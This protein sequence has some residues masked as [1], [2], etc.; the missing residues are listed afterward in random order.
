MISCW[1]N[2]R[3]GSLLGTL[4]QL[5]RR[6]K[7]NRIPAKPVGTPSINFT[8]RLYDSCVFKEQMSTPAI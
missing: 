1:E 2:K 7:Y 5:N 4:N 8:N 6:H 3:P